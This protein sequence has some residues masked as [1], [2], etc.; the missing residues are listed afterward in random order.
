MSTLDCKLIS[1]GAEKFISVVEDIVFPLIRKS[2]VVISVPSIKVVSLPVVI[3]TPFVVE[4]LK[5]STL[6][7]ALPVS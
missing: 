6:K 7:L 3:V 2:P 4:M 1:P 5:L